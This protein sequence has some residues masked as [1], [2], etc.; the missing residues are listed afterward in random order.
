MVLKKKFSILFVPHHNGKV[1]EAKVSVPFLIFILL[2]LAVLFGF[3]LFSSLNVSDRAYQKL[4]LNRLEKENSY[5][6]AK[7]GDLNSAISGLKDQMTDLIDKEEKVRMVFGIPDVDPQIRELGVG[8]P[9]PNRPLDLGPQAKQVDVTEAEVEK[10][11]RQARFEKENF[12]SIYSALS[13]RKQFLDHTP[14]IMPTAGS[15]SCGFGNRVDPFTGRMQPHMGVDLAADIGTP[16]YATADGVV[17]A[18]IRDCGLGR[19]V[20]IDHLHGYITV[21]GHLSQILVKQGQ[22]VKRGEMIGTVGNTGLTTGPHLHYEVYYE[23]KAQNP[24][25][26]FLESEYV[27]E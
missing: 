8:G 21:Y 27:S 5:L 7:L 25:N 18:L 23:G 16:V 1:F 11:L 13:D 6:E 10:L 17:G 22:S 19:V 26:Y 4:K 20:K 3:N 2:D 12:Q 24:L 14:A 9:T 15:F